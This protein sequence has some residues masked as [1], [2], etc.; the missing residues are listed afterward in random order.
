[1]VVSG[2][3]KYFMQKNKRSSK[4]KLNNNL[5]QMKVRGHFIQNKFAE[6]A[7][8]AKHLIIKGVDFK[9][10][11]RQSGKNSFQHIWCVLLDVVYI[12]S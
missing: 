1:M 2:V 9:Y 12:Y 7:Y 8:L 5:V 6:N 4:R 10:Q 11:K 3:V